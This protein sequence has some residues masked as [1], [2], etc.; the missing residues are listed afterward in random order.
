MCMHYTAQA[1]PEDLRKEHLDYGALHKSVG[2]PTYN[3]A[4][5]FSS[6]RPLRLGVVSGDFRFHAMRFFACPVFAARNH[7]EWAL[8]CFSTTAKPDA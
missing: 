4:H 5:A 3:T 8:I 2:Q 1:T 7:D 6:D